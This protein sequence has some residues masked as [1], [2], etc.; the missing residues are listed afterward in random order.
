MTTKNLTITNKDQFFYVINANDIADKTIVF[1]G[2]RFHMEAGL[3]MSVYEDGSISIGGSLT[4]PAATEWNPNPV[5]P[6]CV[7]DDTYDDVDF[8]ALA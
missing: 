1:H 2:T 7:V 5:Y 4:I 8:N 6:Y 3:L